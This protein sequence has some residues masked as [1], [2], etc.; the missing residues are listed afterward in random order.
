MKI[1]ELVQPST[2]AKRLKNWYIGR[3]ND[4]GLIVKAGHWYC[5]R[6]VSDDVTT[7]TMDRREI[8]YAKI[9]K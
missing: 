9:A 1:G 6:W 3:D 5:V 4:I 7:A 2:Y 8:K